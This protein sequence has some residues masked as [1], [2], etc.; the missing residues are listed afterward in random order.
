MKRSVSILIVTAQESI[1]ITFRVQFC[2]YLTV[3]KEM[4]HQ[5]QLVRVQEVKSWVC[6]LKIKCGVRQA[7]TNTNRGY[8][9]CDNESIDCT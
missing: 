1:I 9:H 4:T 8:M 7:L 2:S 3:T 6:R 5:I